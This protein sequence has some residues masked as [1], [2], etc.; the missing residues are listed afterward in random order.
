MNKYTHKELKYMAKH[1]QWVAKNDSQMYW[2]FIKVIQH[3]TDK[4]SNYI[5]KAIEEFANYE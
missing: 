5:E 4:G 1:L 3:Y 2:L